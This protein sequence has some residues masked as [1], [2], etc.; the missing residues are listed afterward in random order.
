M[1]TPKKREKRNYFVAIL[2]RKNIKK[3]G[4]EPRHH[5][6][7][8]FWRRVGDLLEK[9]SS[10]LAMLAVASTVLLV[11]V[12]F[13]CFSMAIL[14]DR[15]GITRVTV[16]DFTGQSFSEI[17]VDGRL[18]EIAPEYRLDNDL[19][20]GTVISQNPSSGAHRMVKK[21]ERLCRV[22]LVVSRRGKLLILPDLVGERAE[23]A[24]ERLKALGLTVELLERNSDREIGVVVST[25][26]KAFSDIPEGSVVK[27]WVS[28]GVEQNML[29]VPALA[30]LSESTAI[31]RLKSLGFE[32]GETE[33]IVSDKPV[34]TVVSQSAPFGAEVSEGSRIYLT[35]SI[36]N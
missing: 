32:V 2:A 3:T 4:G 29:T 22:E 17:D 24:E 13:A 30:G 7:R 20:E 16:P 9:Q 34:G 11:I 18:F 12:G 28:C 14:P 8:E 5:R 27:I 19:P 33:Y 25:Y 15:S 10:T 35:V 6:A 26:P 1:N 21:D 36:G 23:S 31:A